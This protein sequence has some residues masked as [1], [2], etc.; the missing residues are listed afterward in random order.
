MKDN[1]FCIR[2]EFEIDRNF[3]EMELRMSLDLLQNW[4]RM[5][6]RVR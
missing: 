5:E 3:S 4:W 2:Q 6:N 1:V